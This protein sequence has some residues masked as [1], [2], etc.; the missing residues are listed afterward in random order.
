[1]PEITYEITGNA[2]G[3]EK[4]AAE[5]TGAL[6]SLD[7]TADKTGKAIDGKLGGGATKAAGKLDSLKKLAGGIGFSGLANDIDDVAGGLAG[8]GPAA[9]GAA[10]GLGAFAASVGVMAKLSYEVAQ[11][12]YN[13]EDLDKQLEGIALPGF[14]R[15]SEEALDASRDLHGAWSG[16]EAVIASVSVEVGSRA[17]PALADLAQSGLAAALA[18]QDMY[19]AYLKVRDIATEVVG[20]LGELAIETSA[21][22]IAMSGY[23]ERAAALTAAMK[24]QADTEERA[25][26]QKKA[27]EKA[28]RDQEKATKDLT[29]AE[30]EAA[31]WA[32]EIDQQDRAQAKRD[33]AEATRKH[34]EAVRKLAAAHQ[35]LADVMQSVDRRNHEGL[36]A[37]DDR[38]DDLIAKAKENGATQAQL[39]ALERARHEDKMA[40]IDAEA[41]KEEQAADRTA[42]AKIAAEEELAAVRAK[43]DA[44]V[45]SRIAAAFE[46]DAA[47]AKD[48]SDRS[49]AA[50]IQ[51]ADLALT[52]ADDVL[53]AQIDSAK[54]G[55]AA[56]KKFAL[57]AFN[58][59]KA[60]ATSRIVID[61]IIATAAAGASAPPPANL[62]PIAATIA[63]YGSLAAKAATAKPPKFHTGG[64]AP[65]EMLIRK[66]EVPNVMT[67]QGFDAIGGQQG[68][69][70]INRGEA[71]GGGTTVVMQYQHKSSASFFD[72]SLRM[73]NSP[74]RR[75][76][77]GGRRVGH[78]SRG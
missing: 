65:D 27:H 63:F 22:K 19:D 7:A 5:A 26:E 25:K 4:A 40:H 51:G 57:E 16:F 43:L 74:L 76:A 42:A 2:S 41:A 71:A 39:G 77:K 35:A 1:M 32:D 59:Q 53:Q 73:S 24:F 17:A 58:V 68:L 6:R 60:L 18:A 11:A 55:T 67:R 56:Q 15:A 54:G 46:K 9:A 50:A 30:L 61:G 3:L 20:P 45:D 36:D 14:T 69:A 70:K 52:L 78:R 47:L 66:N 44:D 31:K 12:A 75:A 21:L 33:A 48:R 72:D 28:T 8:L 23:E 10:V 64:V 37:I 34:E 29:D 62:I 49:K 38:Y 13:L